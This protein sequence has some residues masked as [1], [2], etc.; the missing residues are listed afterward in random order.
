MLQA[1][2]KRDYHKFSDP[3]LET[4][5]NQ[6]SNGIYTNPLIF[7][8]PPIS[9]AE[10]TNIQEGY[11]TAVSEYNTYGIVKKTALTN[12][13]GKMIS[14][15]DLI[16]SYVDDRAQGDESI[17][18]LAGFEPTSTTMHSSQP[19][20]VIEN[21]TLTRTNPLEVTV[22]IPPITGH[23]SISYFCICSE[24]APIENL[25]IANGQI[26]LDNVTTKIRFDYTKSK[27]KVFQG[28]SSTVTYYFYVFA[29]NAVSV[30]PISMVKSIVAVV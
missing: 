25:S 27:K 20:S 13:R 29:T 18:I 2:C 26:V 5:V 28:L 30:S 9:Q 17:I 21:F 8:S 22:L 7:S 1:K 16:A 24:G 12:S 14:T 6:V 3:A 10:Y 19:L 23:G 11:I 15:V 4:R